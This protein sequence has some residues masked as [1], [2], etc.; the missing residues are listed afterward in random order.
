MKNTGTALVKSNGPSEILAPEP[1]LNVISRNEDRES[2]GKD[3]R[4]QENTRCW[5]F[6]FRSPIIFPS[7]GSLY[8]C[9]RDLN[10]GLSAVNGAAAL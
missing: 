3:S 6:Y 5:A 4:S 1:K 7:M 8:S 9:L 2:G 10:N